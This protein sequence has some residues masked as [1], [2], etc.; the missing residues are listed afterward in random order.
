MDAM[1]LQHSNRRIIVLEGLNQSLGSNGVLEYWLQFPDP[2]FQLEEGYFLCRFEH[3]QPGGLESCF[4]CLGYDNRG[5]ESKLGPSSNNI[6]ERKGASLA[7]LQESNIEK[8]RA[9]TEAFDGRHGERGV[10][11]DFS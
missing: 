1:Q 2:L 10:D 11:F 7:P 4:L 3:L 8:A 6:F 5:S 9:V